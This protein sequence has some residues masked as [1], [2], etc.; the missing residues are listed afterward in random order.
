MKFKIISFLGVAGTL[1]WLSYSINLLT[2]D[3]GKTFSYIIITSLLIVGLL[4]Y[5]IV[6]TRSSVVL[7]ELTKK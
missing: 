7:W 6:G 1:C 5:I 2:Q 3:V 4:I